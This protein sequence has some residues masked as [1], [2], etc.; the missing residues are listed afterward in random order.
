MTI[1]YKIGNTASI[2]A[3]VSHK[4]INEFSKL[5]GDFSPIHSDV[6]F[7]SSIGFEDVLVHSAYIVSLISRLV[8]MQLPGRH[9]ILQRIEVNFHKPCYVP[10]ELTVTGQVLQISEAVSSIVISLKVETSSGEVI[11][12]GKSWHQILDKK[13]IQDE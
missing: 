7:A 6:D 12:T 13:G 4:E 10:V 8:G 9:G 11:V 1:P 2:N 5:S 3:Y